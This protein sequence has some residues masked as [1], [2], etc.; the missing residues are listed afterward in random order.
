[1]KRDLTPLGFTLSKYD[2]ISVRKVRNE[3]A[4]WIQRDTQTQREYGHMKMQARIGVRLPQ[5]RTP[6]ASSS[7]KRKGEKCSLD[8]LEAGQFCTHLAFWVFRFKIY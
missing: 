4:I 3:N 5:S 2:S 8:I 6:A 7:F 1:M